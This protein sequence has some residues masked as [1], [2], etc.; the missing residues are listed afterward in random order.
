MATHRPGFV[1]VGEFAAA[2]LKEQEAGPRAQLVADQIVQL[3]PG[4]AA[5]VYVIEDRDNPSWTPKATA[6]EI[7]VAN[8]VAFQA[9]TLGAVVESKTAMLVDGRAVN[10]EEYSHLDTRRTVTW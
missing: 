8:E 10:R 3:L 1:L 6:G 5:V 4:T 7:S 2:L 9:G